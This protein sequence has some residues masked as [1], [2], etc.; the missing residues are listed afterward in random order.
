MDYIYVAIA[1]NL[2]YDKNIVIF[3]EMGI[4]FKVQ[5]RLTV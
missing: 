4:I 3:T 1:L 2:D 5:L